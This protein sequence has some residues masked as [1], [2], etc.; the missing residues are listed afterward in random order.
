MSKKA[1]LFGVCLCLTLSACM[2]YAPTYVNEN[3]NTVVHHESTSSLDVRTKQETN[4]V[5]ERV[6]PKVTLRSGQRTLA[7]CDAFALPRE[8]LKP[9]YLTD[10]ELAMAEDL[11]AFDTLAATKL[12]ELQIYIDSLPSKYEQAHKQWLEACT[13]KLLH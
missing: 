7:D 5:S 3:Q 13:N 4:E 2:V 8:V 10:E 9:K 11:T 12:K 1:L 6:Y